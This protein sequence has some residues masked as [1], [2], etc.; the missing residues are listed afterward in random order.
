MC[1]GCWRCMQTV[2][3]ITRK[4]DEEEEEGICICK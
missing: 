3:Q 1:S 4:V 2:E